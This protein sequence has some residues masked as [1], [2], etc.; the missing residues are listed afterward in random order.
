MI[1][2]VVSHSIPHESLVEPHSHFDKLSA[3]GF[4]IILWRLAISSQHAQ[5]GVISVPALFLIVGFVPNN[6]LKIN[7]KMAEVWLNR[8]VEQPANVSTQL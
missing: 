7:Q 2:F 3:N 6:V 8:L 4:V 5:I 1:P